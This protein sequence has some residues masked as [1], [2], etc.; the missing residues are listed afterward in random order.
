[1]M[2]F[3]DEMCMYSPSIKRSS[4]NPCFSIDRLISPGQITNTL[5]FEQ[6]PIMFLDDGKLVGHEVLFLQNPQSGWE[7]IDRT[8]LEFLAHSRHSHQTLFVNLSN[9]TLM[10][11]PIDMFISAAKANDI[12]FEISES[13]SDAATFNSLIKKVN[14]LVEFGLRFA[15]DDFGSGRDGMHRLYSINN[16]AVVKVDGLFIQTSMMRKDAACMLKNLVQE[17]KQ[18]GILT[19]AEGIETACILEFA[20]SLGFDAVQ[21]WHVDALI[22]NIQTNNLHQK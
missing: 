6:Q 15:I 7:S 20:R 13:F 21:G 5:Q 9:E 19:V 14:M 17:W 4:S 8:V 1:M 18:N 16:A 2:K 12:I 22:Q 10:N 3:A 11:V